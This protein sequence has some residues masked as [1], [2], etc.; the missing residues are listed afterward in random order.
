MA[1]TV[2]LRDAVTALQEQF[3][4]RL[5]TTYDEGRRL[6]ADALRDRFGIS[7]R[8]ATALVDALV[9]A[10]TIRYRPGTLPAEAPMGSIG[11]WNN[12]AEGLHT[13]VRAGDYWQLGSE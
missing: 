9:N 11:S 13:P 7:G 12:D 6:M 5:E 1:D 4:A 8:E 10:R 2:Q 3:G